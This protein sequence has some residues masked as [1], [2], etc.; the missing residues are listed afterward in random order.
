MVPSQIDTVSRRRPSLAILVAMSAI[1]PL[2][3][4]IFM[5]SMPGMVDVFQTSPAMV[6][7]TLSLFLVAISLSQLIV[8]PLSDHYGRRPILLLGLS[9]FVIGSATC[10]FAPSIEALIAARI[11]QGAGGCAGIVLARTVVRDLFSREKSASMIGYVTMGMAVAPMIGPAIGGYLDELRGWESSF[12]LMILF[13][14]VVLIGAYWDLNETNRHPSP[15]FGLNQTLKS[16]A[17]LSRYRAFWAFSLTSA[18]AT[19]VF[20]SFLGGAPFI[21]TKLMHLTPSQYGLYFVLVAVGYITG[22]FLSGRYAERLGLFTMITAGNILSMLAVTVIGCGFA[23]EL[24][25]PLALFGPMFFTSMANGLTLP[26]A[27]AGAVSVRPDLAGAASGLS[28]SMQ[29][30]AGAAASAIVGALIASDM[31]AAS[32]WPL[33]LV[34]ATSSVLAFITGL[35][36]LGLRDDLAE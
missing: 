26:N 7:L 27:I 4:N 18:F 36:C 31:F 30:G 12:D 34:M 32:G 16:F 28:G 5:P 21:V 14:I 23:L 17:T 35:L 11:V 19:C 24:H 29:I 2:A 20:F 1:S 8:G 33:V 22:N 10:R 25:H 15:T 13:G 3:L 9:L 6:Q